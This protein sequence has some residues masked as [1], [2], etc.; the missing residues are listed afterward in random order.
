[1]QGP[2]QTI[3]PD[4]MDK[5]RNQKE[6]DFAHAE[7]TESPKVIGKA[8]KKPLDMSLKLHNKV[9]MSNSSLIMRQSM[10]RYR[11]A[12][13]DGSDVM[14]GE[15]PGA[16]VD[17]GSFNL[18]THHVKRK[19]KQPLELDYANLRQAVLELFLSVKIRSDEEID[20][21]NKQKFELE[22]KELK[23]VDGYSLIDYI[24][25]SIEMLMNMKMDE[26]EMPEPPKSKPK[27]VKKDAKRY[28]NIDE[29]EINIKIPKDK[30]K[31]TIDSK[32][33]FGDQAA[34]GGDE[35]KKTISKKGEIDLKN[36]DKN[37]K[38]ITIN[39]T[40]NTINSISSSV[41]ALQR[42]LSGVES[43]SSSKDGLEDYDPEDL[44]EDGLNEDV[45]SDSNYSIPMAHREYEK[46]LRQLEAECRTHIKCEQQMKLHIECLQEK[47]DQVVKENDSNKNELEKCKSKIEEQHQKEIEVF[48]KTV[49]NFE[50]QAKNQQNKIVEL[51][52]ENNNIRQEMKNEKIKLDQNMA[53][54]QK[55]LEKTVEQYQRL[56][57]QNVTKNNKQLELFNNTDGLRN[58]QNSSINSGQANYNYK[59]HDGKANLQYQK[60]VDYSDINNQLNQGANSVR[61]GSKKM[62]AQNSNLISS[63]QNNMG[64]LQY[65]IDNKKVSNQQRS[66]SVLKSHTEFNHNFVNHQ[67]STG[68]MGSNSTQRAINNYIT[69]PGSKGTTKGFVNQQMAKK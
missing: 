35:Y 44:D 18:F 68:S 49:S 38:T 12:I 9:G 15:E 34:A 5:K 7:E 65:T 60:I 55:E 54:L 6:R 48:K 66:Q 22:K 37:K 39:N 21:Y 45:T 62:E 57:T 20:A 42:K 4:L 47:L 3:S 2:I 46:T 64:I 11:K 33:N 58:G 52:K 56:L 69:A 59:T 26:Q 25:Q 16:P 13:D 51:Q 36:N 27:K 24:K 63:N 1:M 50:M 10:N 17:D 23:D 8:Q 29:P 40:K 67:N 61:T 28:K 14:I 31:Q 30:N 32:V 19:N 41:A 43:P 53:K